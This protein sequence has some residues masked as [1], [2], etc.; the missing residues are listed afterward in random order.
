MMIPER[1]RL[2]GE[3]FENCNCEILCPCVL[4]VGSGNPTEGDCKIAFA[5]H[6]VE[7]DFS[8]IPVDGLNVV[9]VCYTPGNMGEGNWTSALYIDER[10]D[11]PQRAAL[12]RI[13]SGDVGGPAAVWMGLTTDFRGIKYGP[14]AYSSQGRTRRVSIPGIFD[15][16]V[17][18][19][20]AGS[21]RVMR[22]ENTGHPVAANLAIAQSTHSAYADHGLT[23]DNSGK[24]GHY[25]SFEWS[26]SA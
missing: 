24:N 19:I 5:F 1:W 3:Y 14:I 17:E 18:G 11:P 26:W 21:R 2:K 20:T 6:I 10:A 15:F 13:F 16:N 25:A 22:L 8:D 23:W 12:S 9:L 7:G 4:P